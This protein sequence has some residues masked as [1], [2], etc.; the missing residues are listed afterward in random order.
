MQ[1]QTEAEGYLSKQD[2]ILRVPDSRA[3]WPADKSTAVACSKYEAAT[4]PDVRR[5][6][7]YKPRSNPECCC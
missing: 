7:I 2:R 3:M 6:T 1:R 4:I 5:D